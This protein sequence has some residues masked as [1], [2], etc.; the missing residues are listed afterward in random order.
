MDHGICAIHVPIT[1]VPEAGALIRRAE[2]VGVEAA[3]LTSG[4]YGPETLTT[5]AAIAA[6]TERILLG[7]SVVVTFFRH[8]LITAQQSRAINDIA[9]GRFRL[10]LGTG[11]R[12]TV[13]DAFGLEFDR[14]MGHIRE[15]AAVL[16]AAFD[17]RVAYAGDRF[18]V[19]ASLAR[20]HNVPIYFAALR[21]RGYHLAGE[22][23][24]GAIAWVTPPTFI[25]D[26]AHPAL[27]EGARSGDRPV[28]RL[29]GHV[30]G[31]VSDRPAG[32]LQVARERLALNTRQVYYERMFADAGFPQARDGVVPD[33]L[34]REVALVG[35]EA[36]VTRGLARFFEAGCD[37]VIVSILPGSDEDHERTFRLLGQLR[38][39][40]R[41]D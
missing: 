26:V 40:P 15:Y 30:M 4:G 23:A 17:G 27:V 7:S 31:L 16:R 22:V 8:P 1:T 14:P 28:P 33:E 2:E 38:L 10:G 25:G 5:I 21:R 12:S 34:L 24:D 39:T 6:S 20:P 36:H 9:P 19:N 13:E 32:P 35:D 11:H 37:E 41:G 29:V 18:K 3:W